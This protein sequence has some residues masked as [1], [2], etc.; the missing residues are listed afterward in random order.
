MFVH[1]VWAL[2]NHISKN[3]QIGCVSAIL[4]SISIL[5]NAP[6]QAIDVS[7]VLGG[8]LRWECGL[9]PAMQPTLKS[10]RDGDNRVISCQSPLEQAPKQITTDPAAINQLIQQGLQLLQQAQTIAT[11][12]PAAVKQLIQQ[13][14]QL[15]QTAQPSTSSADP[16]VKQLIQQGLQL[17]QTAQPSVQPSLPAAK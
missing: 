6:A 17:I 15:L 3:I 9:S 5:A 14:L 12:D 16:A 8:N 1:E 7:Q 13:G 2:P 10:N 11:N 4:L